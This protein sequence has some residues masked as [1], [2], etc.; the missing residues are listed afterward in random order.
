MSESHLSVSVIELAGRNAAHTARSDLLSGAKVAM[1]DVRSG[2]AVA[3]PPKRN[4][5]IH[6]LPTR[7]GRPGREGTRAAGPITG[8]ELP[9]GNSTA[10]F[11]SRC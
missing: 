1:N 7:S 10:R 3:K 11:A 6:A 4:S 2:T 5:S 9:S 8:R